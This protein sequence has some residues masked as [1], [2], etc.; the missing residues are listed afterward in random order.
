MTN[1]IS[2]A[3][4]Q[5]A[6]IAQMEAQQT[7]LAKTQAQISSGK[8]VQTPADDP[9]AATQI[10][11]MQSALSQV[12]QY[13]TNA[14]AATTRLS[15]SEQA[16]TSV[17]NVLQHIR[18]LVV[19][20]NTGTVDSSTRAAIATDV[21]SSLQQLQALANQKDSNGDYLFAGLSSQ[22]Q[23]FVQNANGTVSYQGDQGTRSLQLSANSKVADGYSGTQ[24]FQAIPQGNGTFTTAAS[25]SN[26]G[27]AVIDAG[28]IV[29]PA[30]WVKGTYTLQFTSATAYQVV[31]ASNAVVTSGTYQ[32]GSAISFL[33]AQVTVTGP[34]AAGDSFTIA[35]AGKEDIFTSVNRIVTALTTTTDSSASRAQLSSTLGGSLGQL[36]QALSHVSTLKTDVGARQ[37]LV[38]NSTTAGAQLSQALTSQVSSLQDLDYA[39]AVGT[40]N[41]QLLGLQ[42]A[43]AAYAKISQLS[44]FHYL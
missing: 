33:G 10:M 25:A 14:A 3:G 21:Q 23:P 31:D 18:D 32:D 12:A 22:T 30:S 36:D 20:A 24:V 11:T 5:D 1:R 41:Q 26:T 8:R 9:I 35:P 6:V 4:M 13:K 29:T 17:G 2:T 43:Q 15:T 37:N 28:Q 40:M 27:N 42:A 38:D 19:Q 34:P 7:A 16:F 39:Q 44:L